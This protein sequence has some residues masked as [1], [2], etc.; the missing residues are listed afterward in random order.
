[1]TWFVVNLLW[2]GFRKEYVQE[3][4]CIYDYDYITHDSDQTVNIIEK[5]GYF[6]WDSPKTTALIFL[7]FTEFQG[8]PS[9][10]SHLSGQVNLFF[11]VK[12]NQFE[13]AFGRPRRTSNL[14]KS[15]NQVRY[16]SVPCMSFFAFVDDDQ[17]ITAWWV[18]RPK[19]MLEV[20]LHPLL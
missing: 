8:I 18:E 2:R 14:E 3:G 5:G 9:S 17:R 13:T 4:V 1:M 7:E 12:R 16:P 11:W 19:R 15:E 20:V 6:S 10:D